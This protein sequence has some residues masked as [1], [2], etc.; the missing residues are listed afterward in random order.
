MVEGL[1]EFSPTSRGGRPALDSRN[2]PRCA[3]SAASPPPLCS[4]NWAPPRVDG[5]EAADATMEGRRDHADGCGVGAALPLVPGRSPPAGAAAA[6]PGRDAAWEDTGRE[7]CGRCALCLEVG[8]E[9]CAVAPRA[10]SGPRVCRPAPRAE[11][12]QG[13]GVRKAHTAAETRRKVSRAASTADAPRKRKLEL[14]AQRCIYGCRRCRC[15]R[16]KVVDAPACC[17]GGA[18]AS[19]AWRWGGRSPRRRLDPPAD[20]APSS[21]PPESRS[22]P[23]HAE[24][25]PAGNAASGRQRQLVC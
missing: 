24:C 11:S 16:G 12:E 6:V 21:R 25:L 13:K 4:A 23:A 7:P 19:S 20:R 14:R 18:G 8:R 2:P 9:P 1:S 5:L 3:R 22:N 10:E 15:C 17:Q